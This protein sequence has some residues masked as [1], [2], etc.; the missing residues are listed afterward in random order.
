M[1]A[2]ILMDGIVA[3]VE[4]DSI[5]GLLHGANSLV[6]AAPHNVCQCGN[7]EQVRDDLA[8]MNAKEIEAFDPRLL[9][10]EE[11]ESACE[12]TLD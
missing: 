5:E 8:A 9:T 3:V 7:C 12:I 2:M 10:P 4:S 6:T 1:R 11:I